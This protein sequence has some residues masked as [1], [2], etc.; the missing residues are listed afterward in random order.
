MMAFL[1][2]I[3]F[4]LST[5][6]LPV[7]AASDIDSDG[8]I[9]SLDLCPNLPE[10]FV[11]EIDGCPSSTVSWVDSDN[12]GI[13]DSLD[14]CP[15]QSETFNNFQDDDGCPD[16]ISSD[17]IFDQ[18]GDGI[19]DLQDKCPLDAETFNGFQDDDGC[20]DTLV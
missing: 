10:D 3:V 11:G 20:P 12:D 18:D 9:D 7:V 13:I 16:F 6:I 14:L 19:L 1:F 17:R 4:T 5:L 2:L 15:T 8:I